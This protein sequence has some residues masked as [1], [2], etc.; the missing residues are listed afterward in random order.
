MGIKDNT[1]DH[2]STF[3]I[4]SAGTVFT[5]LSNYASQTVKVRSGNFYMGEFAV[6]SGG[7]LVLSTGFDTTTITVGFDYNINVETMP[8]E[9]ALPSGIYKVN[10]K[11]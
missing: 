9:I 8:V 5:G 11:N 4:G 10:Q 3:T 7:Q 1:L 6:T 2:A